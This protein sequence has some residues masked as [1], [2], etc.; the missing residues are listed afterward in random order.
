MCGY[1]N[2]CANE[3]GGLN[4]QMGGYADG[5]CRC[6]CVVKGRAAYGE[7]VL[8]QVRWPDVLVYC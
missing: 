3:E 5:K 6:G 2:E 7:C 8:L 4:G 1:A